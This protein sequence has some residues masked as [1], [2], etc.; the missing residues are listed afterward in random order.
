M[1]QE[2]RRSMIVESAWRAIAKSGVRNLRV[3]E[4][5]ADAGVSTALIY[6]HFGDRTGL[7]E[8]TMAYA[9]EMTSGVSADH[10]SGTG[11]ERLSRTVLADFPDSTAARNNA[12]VWYELVAAAI[13]DGDVRTMV[14]GTLGKWQELI[15]GLVRDGQADGSIRADIDPSFT[16]RALTAQIDGLLSHVIVDTLTWSGA[17]DVLRVWLKQVAA[18]ADP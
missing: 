10:S 14:Q 2:S 17:A 18:Q 7:L 15:L 5:A 11:L 12:V 13:F 9:N 16:A 3:E 1:A 4:V 8:A 6:Y